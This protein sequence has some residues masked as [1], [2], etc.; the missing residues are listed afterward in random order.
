MFSPKGPIVRTPWQ[1][2]YTHP[3]H[4]PLI[5]HDPSLTDKPWWTTRPPVGG[6][7]PSHPTSRETLAP[8]ETTTRQWWPPHPTTPKTTTSYPW[9]EQPTTPK[10]TTKYPWWEHPTTPK[11]TTAYP[12]WEQPTTPST[13]TAVPWWGQS[14]TVSSAPSTP[15]DPCSPSTFYAAADEEL[16]S[17]SG[18]SETDGG[19]RISGGINASPHS[20]PWIAVLFNSQKQFCGGSL[21]DRTHILTAAHCVAHMSQV[22]IQNLR[23]RLGAHN[24]RQ[25]ERTTQEY[26]VARVVRHKDYDSRRLYNDVAMLTLEKPVTFNSK[27]RPVCLD[28]SSSTYEGDRVTVAGWGSMYEGGPQPSTLYKVQLRVWSNEECRIKYGGAAPGG[29][30]SSYLCAGQDGKDSCQEDLT[31]DEIWDDTI[32]IQQYDEASARVRKM[33]NNRTGTTE[34]DVSE[35]NVASDKDKISKKKKK[36]AKKK[37]PWHVG[38]FCRSRFSEDGEI[39]EATIMSLQS[40]RGKAIVRYCGYNN[41]EE[42][43]IRS[44]MKSKGKD[45]RRRQEEAAEVMQSEISDIAS[46]VQE[47]DMQSDTDGERSV[48]MKTPRAPGMPQHRMPPPSFFGSSTHFNPPPY[49]PDLPP[50]P[51][52]SMDFSEDPRTSEA[53]HTMLMSWYMTGYHTGYYQGLKQADSLKQR[54]KHK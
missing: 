39:Y 28:R 32:L 45:F 14:S 19:F 51:A 47:S 42:V 25:Q 30:V 21:I 9:W 3:T 20:H 15:Q 34:S 4:P 8:W 12:F 27:V 40:E 16:D 10:T 2:G 18:E 1:D 41:E 17:N 43:A 53:L 37:V 38:D 35:V 44:L 13:T 54:K 7:A 33:I 49:L 22:D 26:K 50:P 11:T 29:I 24:I 36:K 52:L 48:K 6:G 31:H 23:V 5:T 46:S